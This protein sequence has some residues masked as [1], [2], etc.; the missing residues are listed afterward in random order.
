MSIKIWR[1]DALG[2]QQIDSITP[3]AVNVGNV[4]SVTINSKTVTFTAT[5]PTVANV[6]AGLRAACT[7]QGV[8]P[9]F[10]EILWTDKSTYLEAKSQVFGRPF[11]V[12][13]SATGG[14]TLQTLVTTANTGPNNWDE[15]NNWQPTGLPVNNDDVYIENTNSSIWYG[16][17]QAA[18]T[19]NSLNIAASFTG[20]IGLPRFTATNYYEYRPPWLSISAT[21]INIGSGTGNGSGRIKIDS[22]TIQTTMVILGSGNTLENGVEAILWKGTHN[23]NQVEITKGT[24]GLAPFAGDL[25]TVNFLRVGFQLNAQGDSLVRGGI[26]LT[27]NDVEQSGGTIN[28][29]NAV[30]TVNKTDGILQVFGSAPVTNLNIY[31]GTLNWLSN[32]AITTLT[33]SGGSTIDFSKDMRPFA[34]GTCNLYGRVK[35]LDPYKRVTYGGGTGGINL[36]FIG[37]EDLQALQLGKNFKIVPQVVS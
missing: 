6:T 10:G 15:P 18:V 36:N 22:G 34:I 24:L 4:F 21:N 33:G 20:Q 23:L 1:G 30:T 28:L 9:E 11:T 37:I 26:G 19:L 7:A 27:L 35:Y 14:A 12:S 13:T 8:P 2:V 32:G 25:A 3:G 16:I 17:S 5:T 29:N 31:G